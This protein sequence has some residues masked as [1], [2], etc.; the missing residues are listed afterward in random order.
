MKLPRIAKVCLAAVALSCLPTLASAVIIVVDPRD[1]AFGTDISNAYD[2]VTMHRLYQNENTSEGYDPV[3]APITTAATC[4]RSTRPCLGDFWEITR[5]S[6]CVD[7][8]QRGIQSRY[9]SLDPW[10]VLELT[11]DVPTD[12]VQISARFGPDY[13]GMMLYD[14]AS[15]LVAR[16]WGVFDDACGYNYHI[17]PVENFATITFDATLAN[18]S[19]VIFS[20]VAGSVA[21]NQIVYR[22]NVPEPGTLALLGVGLLGMGLSRRRRCA[23][24]A[25]SGPIV[26]S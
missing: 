14:S 11:F 12:L 1:H 17:D 24:K 16:C 5:W 6:Q 18:V 26:R 10:S 21:A 15:N 7:A 13:P 8:A 23:R 4:S 19:R 22:Q 9:C 20:G 3:S 25:F 2:G